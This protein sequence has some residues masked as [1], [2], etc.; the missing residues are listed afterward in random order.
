MVSVLVCA[1]VSMHMVRQ[2]GEIHGGKEFPRQQ[3]KFLG[4]VE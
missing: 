4:K 1:C 3:T 2:K